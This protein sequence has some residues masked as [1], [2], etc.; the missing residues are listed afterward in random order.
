MGFVVQ[1]GGKKRILLQWL[2]GP[3]KNDETGH[4]GK[5]GGGKVGFGG[6]QCSVSE[7]GG[8]RGTSEKFARHLGGARR[9]CGRM[10]E[11][12]LVFAIHVVGHV[13]ID[14]GG[15]F[16]HDCGTGTG[17]WLVVVVVVVVVGGGV[18]C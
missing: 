1:C 14:I 18:G 3:K 9:G 16:R 15:L 6:T 5:C 4:Q 10:F 8:G 7:R 11:D 13:A 17:G 2:H 12:V